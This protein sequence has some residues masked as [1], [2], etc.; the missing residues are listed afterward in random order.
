MYYRRRHRSTRFGEWREISR[1]LGAAWSGHVLVET[2]HDVIIVGRR[3]G[4]L[5]FDH[6]VAHVALVVK[7]GV[8][9]S[10]GQIPATC[11]VDFTFSYVGVWPS[12]INLLVSTSLRAFWTAKTPMHFVLY[13]T[14]VLFLRLARKISTR[15]CDS[16]PTTEI[17]HNTRSL[18]NKGR[19]MRLSGCADTSYITCICHRRL[20]KAVSLT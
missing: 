15:N 8:A 16:P 11:H 12:T 14:I 1:A 6:L 10:P 7:T 4:G 17:N 18:L 9:E 2:R 13:I 19:V 3:G 20:A 5:L